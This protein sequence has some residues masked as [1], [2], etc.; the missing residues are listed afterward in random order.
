MA[1]EIET[2]D[3]LERKL[4]LSLAWEEINKEVTIRLKDTQKRVRLDGFRPGKTPLK[5]IQNMY[6][7]SIQNDVLNDKAFKNFYKIVNDEKIA[8]AGLKKLEALPQDNDKAVIK[9]AAFFEVIPESIELGDLS[10][11]ELNKVVCEVTDEDVEKTL[12]VL[13]KQRVKYESVTRA[14]QETDRATIDFT[15]KIDGEVF[16]GG[17]AKD[18]SIILG[19]GQMLPEFEKAIINLKPGESK[20]NIEINFPENYHGKDV[21]GKKAIFTIVLKKLEEEILPVL[22][23]E[24]ARSLGIENGDV[25]KMKEEIKINLV[26]EVARRVALVNK[27]A[28]IALL[29]DAASFDVPKVMVEREVSRLQKQAQQNF[30]NQGVSKENIPELPE[31]L[32]KE[33]AEKS[34]KI[35]LILNQIMDKESLVAT[36]EQVKA[37]IEDI[38]QNYEDPEEVLRYYMN[39]KDEYANAQSMATEKNIVDFVLA[40]VKTK[41]IKQSFD[42]LMKV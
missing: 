21:A 16:E 42:E 26:R 30:L 10:K 27:E 23:Q 8:L 17:S 3:G 38:A 2:L 12:K 14:A 25:V 33:K 18:Y 4:I 1:V 41:D 7:Q 6:G 36:K 15:G 29:L 9:V 28:V 40:K 37:V 19:S 34:V 32:F 35:G 13:Q 5:M 24:F 31:D 39:N 20:D 11:K 22:D